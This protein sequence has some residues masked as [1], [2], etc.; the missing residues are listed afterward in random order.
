MAEQGFKP[1]LLVSKR[2]I[3]TTIS[4]WL[5]KGGTEKWLSLAESYPRKVGGGGGD[6][7][8]GSHSIQFLRRTVL[9]GLLIETIGE[10][11]ING[12]YE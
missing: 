1:R 12:L 3:Q 11:A 2:N 9:D 7:V 4:C 8:V 5:S 6:E 10:L